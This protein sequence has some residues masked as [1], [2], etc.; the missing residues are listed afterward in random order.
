MTQRILSWPR[1]DWNV[2]WPLS[3]RS[4][5]K[6]RRLSRC[7]KLQNNWYTTIM[8]WHGKFVPYVKWSTSEE[9]LVLIMSLG[10]S[11]V[12]TQGGRASEFL[13]HI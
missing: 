12:L 9:V 2:E 6:H 13:F 7:P 3:R 4:G 11:E 5:G 8:I 1:I 10:W